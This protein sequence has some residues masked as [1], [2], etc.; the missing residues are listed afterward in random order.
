MEDRRRCGCVAVEMECAAMMA[1]ARFRRIPFAQFLYGGDNLDAEVW[2]PRGLHLHG[3]TR[4]EL[5]MEIALACALR[6]YRAL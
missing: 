1:V 3:A 4:A 5:Y 2:D 6:L